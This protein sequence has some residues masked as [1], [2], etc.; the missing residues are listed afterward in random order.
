[1]TEQQG[2]EDTVK[3]YVLLLVMFGIAV[4]AL[5]NVTVLTFDDLT[6]SDPD[7]SQ[8]VPNGYGGFDWSYFYFM[9]ASEYW[10]P[11]VHTSG[12][13]MGTVSGNVAFNAWAHVATINDDL[14]NFEGAYLTAAWNDGLQV[15]VKGFVAGVEKY[16]ETVTLYTTARTWFDF[17]FM[18]ID[19]LEFTS[20]G[21]TDTIP[22]DAGSGG[23]FAMDNFTYSVIPAPGALLL[24]SMGA[25]LVGWLRRRR[26]V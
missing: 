22:G 9:D 6:L 3:K 26:V 7:Y 24:G 25:G 23:H 8:P 14:F 10:I 15:D 20:H 12:Y 19:E 21:G 18:G 2:K 17:D 16:S 13:E 1:L 11:A 4:P 5:A